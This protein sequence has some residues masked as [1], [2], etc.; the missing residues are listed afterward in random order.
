MIRKKNN[1]YIKVTT[2]NEHCNGCRIYASLKEKRYLSCVEHNEGQCICVNCIVK[3]IPRCSCKEWSDWYHSMIPS[4]I[5]DNG[6]DYYFDREDIDTF[7]T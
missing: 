2:D 7:S 1:L 3:M 4:W 5:E 6:D